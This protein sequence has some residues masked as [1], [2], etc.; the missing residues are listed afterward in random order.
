[1]QDNTK[2]APLNQPVLNDKQIKFI[3]RLSNIWI[4][5][6]FLLGKLP[7]GFFSG[8][9]IKSLTTETCAATI[10]YGW[11]TRNPFRSTY[12]AALSMAAELSTGALALLAIEG[13]TVAVIIVQM[14]AEFLKMA[15]DTTTF[16]CDEGL[17]LSAS[18]QKALESGEA[19]TAKVLTRGLSEKGVE[20]ARF[21]FTWSFKRRAR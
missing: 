2:I 20:V 12:F 16:T 21:Y 7:L 9:K 5:K 18:A 3:A 1:M 17:L 14:E 8:M 4:F 13:K 19:V 15:K 6:L 10:P 11:I